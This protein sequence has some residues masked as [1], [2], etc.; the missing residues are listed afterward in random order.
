[1]YAIRL[2]LGRELEDLLFRKMQAK[3]DEEELA[4]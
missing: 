3:R 2:E 1:M 4:E